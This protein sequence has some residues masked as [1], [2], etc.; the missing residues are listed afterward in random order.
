MQENARARCHKND[1]FAED[2]PANRTSIPKDD[3][4]R[5]QSINIKALILTLIRAFCPCFVG[6]ETQEKK[7]LPGRIPRKGFF[8]HQYRRGETT[9]TTNSVF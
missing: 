6:W 2:Q 1:L 3:H 9:A 8:F 5:R 4:A 7:P